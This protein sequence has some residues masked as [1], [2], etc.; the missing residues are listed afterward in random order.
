[1]KIRRFSRIPKPYLTYPSILKEGFIQS[2]VKQKTDDVLPHV[3]YVVDDFYIRAKHLVAYNKVCGFDND[4]NI[5]A[6]YFAVLSQ[7]LQMHMMT[8]E[9]FPFTVLSLVHIGNQVKQ[10]AYLPANQQ[11]QL[12]C[13]FGTTQPHS[14]GVEFDFIIQV[15]AKNQLVMEGISTYL[16]QPEQQYFN[17]EISSLSHLNLHQQTTWHIPENIGRRY[18]LVSGDFNLIHLHALTAK[19]FGFN[20]AVAH[21]MWS[22]AKVMAQLNLPEKYHIDITFKQPIDLPTTV[23]LQSA[24]DENKTQTHFKLLDAQN[25][26]THADGQWSA[27]S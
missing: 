11:Y 7:A 5:P 25:H 22:K 19:A 2:F 26:V 16:Y 1:M 24:F 14:H 3:E 6:I 8:Q 20:Q 13:R 17:Q 9:N 12:S 27:L 18:A 23:Q 4:G 21:G 15:H 10:H